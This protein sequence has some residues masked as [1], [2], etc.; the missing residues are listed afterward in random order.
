MK[1]LAYLMRPNTY[2]DIVGQ[3][4]LVGENGIIKRM[5]ESNSLLSFILYGSPGV[6]KQPLLKRHVK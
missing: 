5:L 6:G 2:Q 4:H 3:E 1:P